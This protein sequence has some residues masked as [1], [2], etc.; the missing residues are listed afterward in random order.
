MLQF[1]ANFFKQY[2]YF[3]ATSFVYSG[4]PGDS[5]RVG[6][7]RWGSQS[8][9]LD[10]FE[11]PF[12][13]A[14][15]RGDY[16]VAMLLLFA[17]GLATSLTPCVYPMITITVGVFGAKQAESRLQGALLSTSFVFGI[18]AL[19]TP[20]G[21][22]AAL[23]GGVFGELLASQVVLY[24]L[25]AVFALLAASM[26]GAFD[27]A[28]PPA[29]QTK[30]AQ[31]GGVG[32]RGA[33]ALGLVS[34]VIAAP[35]TGPVL[36]FL[37]PWIGSSGNLAFG[38]FGLSAYALGLGMLF[39][40]VGTFAVSLPKSG[41]WLEWVKS[42]F[43]IVMLVAAVYYVR[44]L[45]PLISG[46]A[47]RTQFLLGTSVG[48]LILGLALGAVDLSFHTPLVRI[49]I[50]KALAV[51]CAM[52]GLVGLLLYAEA[53][54][55]GAKISWQDDLVAAR[56]QAK[57]QGKPMLVDFGASWCVACGELDRHTFSDPRIVRELKRFVT[58]RVDLSPGSINDQKR[59]WLGSYK[60]NGLPLVVVHAVNG[61]EVGRITNFVQPEAMLEAL[62]KV[63]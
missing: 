41:E 57:Q 21:L 46:I 33:F 47:V 44:D 22:V 24:A 55:P 12:K 2:A 40:F 11:Q 63:D 32:Y 3:I 34:A 37:L 62:Q 26:F 19:F 58:V 43:G 5:C 13:D 54:P 17:A 1:C 49:R 31:V 9:L 60:Q 20:L 6:V 50:Q 51:F 18:V 7:F 29:L 25:A 38:A 28:L 36:G 23:S 15:A 45:V 10:G 27:L 42:L 48:L 39:W 35:C 14:L 30:L 61:A 4:G 16:S 52:A 8:G 56:E 53:L 59:S